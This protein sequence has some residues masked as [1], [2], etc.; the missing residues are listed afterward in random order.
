MKE[1]PGIRELFAEEVDFFEQRRSSKRLRGDMYKSITPD[2]YGF[3]DDDDGV[4]APKEQ[5]NSF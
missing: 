2:Y 5:V 3:R 4:L 1:L